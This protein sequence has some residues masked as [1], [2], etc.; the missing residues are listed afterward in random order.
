MKKLLLSKDNLA[1]GSS[2]KDLKFFIHRAK[3]Q[4]LYRNFL[5]L[6]ESD[7]ERKQVRS[8]FEGEQLSYKEA[9]KLLKTLQSARSTTKTLVS[10]DSNLPVLPIEQGDKIEWPWQK[11]SS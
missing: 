10:T 2:S 4:L 7:S 6:C 1:L 5:R 9:E 3:V 8:G 11:G